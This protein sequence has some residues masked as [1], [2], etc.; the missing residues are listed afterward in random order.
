MF[1]YLMPLLVMRSFP[2]TL[3]DQTYRGA[4]RRQI[5]Y[6]G[7]RSV[8]WGIS[9]SAYN[10]RD[11]HMT[12]QYRGFGGLTLLQAWPMNDL[13]APMPPH[14]RPPSTPTKPCGTSPPRAGRSLSFHL[15]RA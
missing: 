13:R 11:R 15:R 5:E 4:V 9:E 6:G 14:S 10:V 12:Y 2:Y 7:E 8:P 1:E 3:L